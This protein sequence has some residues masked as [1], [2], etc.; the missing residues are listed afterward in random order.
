MSL[1]PFPAPVTHIP[2]VPLVTHDA[3]DW[4]TDAIDDLP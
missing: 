4:A 1:R 3:D 2:I